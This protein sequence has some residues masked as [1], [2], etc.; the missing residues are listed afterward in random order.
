MSERETPSAKSFADYASEVKGKDYRMITACIQRI[1]CEQTKREH[2]LND[3][4]A[5]GSYAAE[6]GISQKEMANILSRNLTDNAPRLKAYKDLVKAAP[7]ADTTGI[8]FSP[9]EDTLDAIVEELED[10]FEYSKPSP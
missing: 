9:I 3:Q 6:C 4:T 7:T 1:E 2:L 8:R 5:L 10:G